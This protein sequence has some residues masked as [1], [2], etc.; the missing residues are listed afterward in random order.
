VWLKNKSQPIAVQN[1]VDYLLA[2]LEKWDGHGRVLE[3]GGPEIITYQDLML[4]YARIRGHKRRCFLL[5]YVSVSFMAFGIGLM[6]PVS[7][8]IA[9][10]LVEGLSHDSI[11]VYNDA[12]DIYPEIKLI[13]SDTATKDAL[14][15]L[16]PLKIER[17]W[18]SDFGN[19]PEK[20]SEVYV[21]T[22][23]HEGFFIDHREIKVDAEPAKVFDT[24]TNFRMRRFIVDTIEPD[25]LLL[26]RSQRKV[27]GEGWV[28]WRVSHVLNVTYITQT[29]YFT[30]RGLGGFLY[31]Y[32]LYPF[33]AIVFRGLIRAIARGALV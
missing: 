32:L 11:V 19:L 27:P 14:T 22:L 6:T 7:H 33:H 9:R 13:D 8:P 4:R 12:R 23:K 2:A 1:V 24:I 16:H 30:P 28:E 26:L 20:T 21:S 10:A 18:E 3:I 31:W 29:I 5:P 15:R 25:H 17:V